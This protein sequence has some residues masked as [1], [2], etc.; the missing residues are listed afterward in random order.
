MNNHELQ[1]GPSDVLSYISSHASKDKGPRYLTTPCIDDISHRC[2]VNTI[3]PESILYDKPPSTLPGPHDQVFDWQLGVTLYKNCLSPGKIG[4]QTTHLGIHTSQKDQSAGLFAVDESTYL[5]AIG[6]A[7]RI[8]RVHEDLANT[9]NTA[10]NNTEVDRG[11]L[12]E[13]KTLLTQLYQPLGGEHTVHDFGNLVP[14]FE[15]KAQQ[16]IRELRVKK[17]FRPISE[18]RDVLRINGSIMMHHPIRLPV[19]RT[20]IK[21]REDCLQ[22]FVEGI[23]RCSEHRI[24]VVLV[25]QHV[26]RLVFGWSR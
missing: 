22:S 10:G 13:A 8:N 4:A 15:A 7:A 14:T 24:C 25:L 11:V 19:R 17:D 2:R 12:E 26:T 23:F 3:R 20:E 21:G 1:G 6:F 9:I 16:Y 18:R 5:S